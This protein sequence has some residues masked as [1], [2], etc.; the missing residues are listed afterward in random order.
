[1]CP[2]RDARET[3]NDFASQWALRLAVGFARLTAQST[4]ACRRTP[5]KKGRY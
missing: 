3:V 4:S 1:M 5:N 2:R